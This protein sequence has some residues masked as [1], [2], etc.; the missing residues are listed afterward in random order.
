MHYILESEVNIATLLSIYLI[1][2]FTCGICAAANYT[3]WL[4]LEYLDFP[5]TYYLGQLLIIIALT[6]FW[7][8]L[9]L[10]FYMWEIGNLFKED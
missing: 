5:S 7:L 1:I 6:F 2:G 10:F 9:L 4:R 3:R 8:P